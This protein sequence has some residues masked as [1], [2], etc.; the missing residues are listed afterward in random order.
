MKR[1]MRVT[2]LVAVLLLIMSF[3]L[4]MAADKGKYPTTPKKNK[5]KK[6]R[7]GYL[8]GGRYINYPIN[9]RELAAGFMEL[10][11]M[12][13]GD[14]PEPDETHDARKIWTWLARNGKSDYIQFVEDAF[15]SSNFDQGLRTKTNE[16]VLERLNSKRDIDF[17]I[18][19]GTWAGQDLANDQHSVP[20]MVMSTSDPI[21]SKIIKSAEDS[22]FDHIH[23][24]VDPTRYI[25]QVRLFHEIIGFKKM[26]IAY[27]NSVD[28]RTYS[29]I[30]DVEKVAKEKGFEVI[31]CQAPFSGVE[32]K[33]ATT[34]MAKCY[35]ELAPKVDAIYVTVHRGVYPEV[36]PEIL[37]PLFKYKIPSFS[38]RGPVE[39][40]HGVLLSIAR[41]DFSEVG[42]WHAAVAA[43]IFNGAKARELNQI[44]EDPKKIALNIKTALLIGYDPPV[45]VLGAA[46]EIY[47]E[48]A[49]A[50]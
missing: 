41:A 23:A 10:G 2:S 42:R 9:L 36:M 33:V 26:G 43:K 6:W 46:D 8:E 29:A 31:K 4:V 21:Q 15:W 37:A 32:R 28:G 50:N 3:S 49:K 17:M 38:Q 34:G 48:I 18:A 27:E 7:I 44:F 24:K 35:A 19:M 12:E 47:E 16:D 45:D 39:V 1:G 11:W 14:I 30:A 25:R 40:E 22:G 13:K 5:G 20:T